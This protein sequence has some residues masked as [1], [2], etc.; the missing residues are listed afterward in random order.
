MIARLLFPILIGSG[1][2]I[3]GTA[4]GWAIG[5]WPWLP[6][7]RLMKWW[8][9][10]VVRRI[11]RAR[12]WLGCAAG[13]FLNN[14]LA[15]G[16]IVVAGVHSAAAWFA[17]G[18]LGMGLGIGLRLMLNDAVELDPADLRRPPVRRRVRIGVALNMLEPPAIAIA[19]G[20]SLG[21]RALAVGV[22][23]KAAWE[24][25]G[26]TVVPLL[27]VSALGEALWLH[28]S[29]RPMAINRPPPSADQGEMYD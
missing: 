2:V 16:L 8:V 27:L 29:R 12:T 21:Q 6:P 3:G 22:E 14:T 26:M 1:L 11:L 10:H 28:A 24:T 15:C 19:T 7:V 18:G 20:L 23:P 9:R 5:R 17:V 13:I 4:G 25:F